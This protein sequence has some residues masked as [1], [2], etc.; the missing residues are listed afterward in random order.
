MVQKSIKKNS[1]YNIIKLGSTALFSLIA[2]PYINRILLTENI[3]KINF[4]L[5]IV[6]YFSLI[7]TLGVTTYAIRECSKVRDDKAQLS[8]ISRQIFSI[9]IITTAIAYVLLAI[10]LLFYRDLHS[11]RTLIVIQSL[12]IIATTVGA[13]WLNSAME[14]FRYITIKT[15]AFQ[16]VS[17]ILMV[18]LIHKPEDYIKYAVISLISSSGASVVNIWYRKRYCSIH[19]LT[20]NLAWQKHLMPI[21]YLFVMLLAQTIFH[22][23]DSTMLGLIHGDHEVGIY[24]VAHKTV[25]MISQIVSSVLWIIMPR[26]SYYFAKNDYTEINALLRKILGFNMLLGLPCVVG[27]FFLAE[28]V[29]IIIAGQA[30]IDAAPVLQILMIGFLL[31]LV[32]GNLLG[33]A[34][35]LPSRQEKY[36][37]IVCCITAVVNVV[38]NYI[39]IPM[40]GAKAAA[41]TTAVCSLVI[42][43]LLFLKVDKRIKIVGIKKAVLSPL[44]GCLGIMV[45]CWLCKKG[46]WG[47]T[48]IRGG[49]VSGGIEGIE[50]IES[51][52]GAGTKFIIS[53]IGSI[54]VYGGIQILMKNE[55]VCDVLVAAKRRFWGRQAC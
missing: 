34:I 8:L 45:V 48:E 1:V 33:N 15:V 26:M 3:G 32:G 14:D 35:L 42:L 23:V 40:F 51:I 20:R 19:F 31:S 16:C 38:G 17:L 39:F 12:S 27:I 6:S 36:Y 4:G 47:E 52:G 7:A 9:N 37:M 10:V 11:Y 50:D 30:F 55:L 54:A 18:L 41:G 29:I 49:V 2:F 46:L 13:D 43:V 25:S 28:E 21:I 24:S 44:V 22:S 5:S 53:F